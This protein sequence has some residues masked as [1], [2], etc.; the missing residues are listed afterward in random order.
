MHALCWH[1]AELLIVAGGTYN[2]H[3]ALKGE[4]VN[5]WI[6]LYAYMWMVRQK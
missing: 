5:E 4:F 6:D 1:N 2:Y 3:W